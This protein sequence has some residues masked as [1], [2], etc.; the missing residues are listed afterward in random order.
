MATVGFDRLFYAPITEDPE[1]GAETYG[2]PV[3]LAKA[4]SAGLSVELAEA[5]L[6]ADDAADEVVREFKSAKLSLGVKDLGTAQAAKLT[7]ARVDDNGALVSAGEDGGDYV[8]VGFRAKATG[9]KHRLYWLYR[10]KF[11]VP[12]INL[13]THGDNINFQT[14]TI[15]GTALRRNKPDAQGKHPWMAELREGGTGVDKAVV[16]GWFKTVY[17]PGFGDVEETE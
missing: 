15:E 2:E 8:A 1:T 6:Y 14:P 3:F 17:E 16:D 10:V 4:I 12:S 5:V 7:G 13:Q 9:N 11:A